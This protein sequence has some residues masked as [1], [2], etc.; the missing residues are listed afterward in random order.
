MDC[1]SFIEELVPQP[2]LPGEPFPELENISASSSKP[3]RSTWLWAM[4]D[5]RGNGQGLLLPRAVCL[6][7][8]LGE[9]PGIDKAAKSRL[10]GVNPRQT[11]SLPMGTPAQSSSMVGSPQSSL[12]TSLSSTLRGVPEPPSP[13]PLGNSIP[14]TRE[15]NY[16]GSPEIQERDQNPSEA[17]PSS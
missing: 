8:E 6:H 17:S 13:P 15:C 4:A 16:P 3:L 11:A 9:Q 2:W 7:W 10:K 1:S 12:E 5:P 14:L